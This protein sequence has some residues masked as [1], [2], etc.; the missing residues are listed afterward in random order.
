VGM[1]EFDQILIAAEAAINVSLFS[2]SF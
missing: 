1:A 2:S